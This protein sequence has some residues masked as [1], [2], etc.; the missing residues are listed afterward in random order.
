MYNCVWPCGLKPTKLLYPWD[1]PGKNTG[2]GC[3][4]LLQGIFPTQGLNP[5]LLSLLHWQVVSLP[6]EPPGNPIYWESHGQQGDQ[7]VSPKG[8]QPCIFIGTTDAE[9][10]API[11]WPYDAK[12]QLIG[13]GS[14]AGKIEGRR[15]RGW[16][17][18]R[19]LDGITVSMDMNMG[20]L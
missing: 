5:S 20:K 18:M 7:P 9:A 15:R 14:D 17:R 3:H 11:I 16:Q 12:G 19:K 2:M 8:N 6:L 4:F 10:E 13:K 1:P